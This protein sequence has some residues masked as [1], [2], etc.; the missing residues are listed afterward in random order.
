MPPRRWPNRMRTGGPVILYISL[1]FGCAAGPD[2]HVPAAVSDAT[3][4]H[5]PLPAATTQAEGP[6][7]AAQHFVE[8]ESIGGA[9]WRAFGSADL[10]RLVQQALD[11]SPTLAQARMRLEQ[12]R[13]DY[14][15]QVGGSEWPQAN[16]SLNV[17]REK[18]D[19]AA[20]G[21]GSLLGNRTFPP[22]TLY[23]AQVSVSYSV[24]L[25]GVNR[26]TV[27]GLAALI[28]YQQYEL[29][30]ARLTLAGNVVTAVIR[31]ASLA[32]QVDLSERILAQQT[33][34]LQIAE[35]RRGAGGISENDLLAQRSQL[36]QTRAGIA[37][38]RVQ[39]AQA[40]H[41]LAVY[42]GRSPAQ[43]AAAA[44]ALE[45]LALPTDLPL[46]LPATLAR[47]RPDIRAS[48]AL[49]HQASANVGVA[50]ANL[51]PQITLSG[52]T[53]PEGTQ[54]SDLVNVWA[55][56]AGLTQPIFHGGQLRA[57]RRSAQAAY[58]VAA[59]AYRQTVLQGLQQVADALRTVEQDAIQ[60]DARDRAQ[61]D[62]AAS[63]RVAE[64]RYTAGGLS[65]LSL[66]DAQRQELQAALDR[67]VAHAQRLSDTAAL[68]QALGAKP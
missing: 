54:L 32:E 34:Q 40:E 68:Y 18:I 20:F 13:Q 50:T 48:E 35:R 38:L 51:Y 24:D 4:T 17:T 22:F 30:A 62:A 14:A 7:G 11:D 27:E 63:A 39:L 1:L 42:L 19:P 55:V 41:Q 66:L 3:Y 21:I 25:F 8:V 56:G 49:L 15:A 65:Q 5:G 59:A 36:E 12:A 6:G 16:A 52:S 44:P 60:L 46:T 26:R 28:D 9:W 64:Q 57:R 58:E 61:R 31:R 23:Q 67:T 43:G 29:D 2:F 53:G 45:Q 37:P 47:Q 33:R 10:D